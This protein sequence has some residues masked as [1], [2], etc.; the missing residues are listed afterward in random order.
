MKDGICKVKRPK[1]IA[2]AFDIDD[3][4][5]RLAT[6][7]PDVTAQMSN[8]FP[9]DKGLADSLAGAGFV[10]ISGKAKAF[11]EKAAAK[12]VEYLPM[13]VLDHKGAIAS[14]DYVIVNP[15][16]VI[17]CIDLEASSAHASSINKGMIDGCKKLVLR[18]AAV[19]A[20]LIVFRTQFW[21]GRIL[22]RRSVADA[23][24][25]AGLTGMHFIEPEKYTGLI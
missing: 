12:N 20:D 5:P 13:T 15:L 8:R 19:P 25:A 4:V 3:G 17:D 1:G 16:D 6:W 2:D 21:S 24:L 23:M 14:S 9:K 18:E 22:I 7:T 11:L 10:V